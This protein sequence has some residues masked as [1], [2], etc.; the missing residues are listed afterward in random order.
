MVLYLSGLKTT[1]VIEKYPIITWV[2]IWRHYI[3]GVL[4]GSILGPLLFILY[5]NDIT[6]TSN[7]LNFILFADDTTILCSH[8]AIGSK[9]TNYQLM[10]AKLHT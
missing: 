3:C 2:T 7:V 1:Y 6:Y 10:P 5:V 4:Q 9:Q 8:E